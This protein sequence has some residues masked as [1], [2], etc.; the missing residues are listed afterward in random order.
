MDI[1][2]DSNSVIYILRKLE[3][4]AVAQRWCA[5]LAKYDFKIHY[6]AG[7]TNTVA[8]SLSRMTDPEQLDPIVLKKWCTDRI[9]SEDDTEYSTN[10]VRVIPDN[11]VQAIFASYQVKVPIHEQSLVAAIQNKVDE[12]STD[13]DVLEKIDLIIKDNPHVDFRVLQRQDEG[14]QYIIETVVDDPEVKYS[15]VKDKSL[16][17]KSLFKKRK[18]LVLEDGLLYKNR[19][20][21]GIHNKQLIINNSCVDLLVKMYH[22]Q[23]AHLGQERTIAIISERFY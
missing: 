5:E 6:K 14:I 11:V 2:T 7:K 4:D 1:H 23:Q 8:D 22:E 9:A 18:H 17:I 12:D 21:D 16:F 3:I 10:S 19:T 20:K 15:S 13:D